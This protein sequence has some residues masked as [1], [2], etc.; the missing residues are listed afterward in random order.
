L[1]SARFCVVWSTTTVL[2]AMVCMAYESFSGKY[3]PPN[4][5][6]TLIQRLNP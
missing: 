4:F 3:R 1:K 6:S 5:G 2:W